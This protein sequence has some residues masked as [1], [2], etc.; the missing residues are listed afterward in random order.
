MKPKTINSLM[1]CLRDDKHIKIGGSLQKKKL[2]YMGY[3][4]GY[5]GYRYCNSPTTLLPYT[6]FNEIQAVYDFDMKIKSLMYP[7]IM[8]LETALKNFAL[9]CILNDCNSKRFAD[10]FANCLTNYKSF[11]I[12]TSKYAEAMNKRLKLREHI[13]STISRDY[14]KSLVSHYYDKDEPV[15]VWA[16]FEL[17]SLGEFGT[18][19]SCLNNKIKV[20]LSKSIGI[21]TSDDHD[22]KFPEMLVFAIKDLRNAIAHNGTVFDT[23]FKTSNINKRLPAYIGKET[24]ISNINFDSIVDYVILIAFL[25]KILKCNKT[26][27]I[28]FI[29]DFEKICESLYKQVPTNIYMRIV[30]TDTRNK[31]NL[32]K[33]FCKKI[34]YCSIITIA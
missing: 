13:Y 12:G 33:L 29:T 16:I 10:V 22:G 24:G 26:D 31:L 23:R 8:F 7:Q 5:K 32:L 1:S 30:Y 9:E 15:P 6:D 20:D 25:L 28:N 2:R 3:F 21:K 14:K 19:L 27:I 17:I 4:H 11:S 18:F 34:K